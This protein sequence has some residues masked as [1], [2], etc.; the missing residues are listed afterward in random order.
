MSYCQNSLNL[1]FL[2]PMNFLY[3]KVGGMITLIIPPCLKSG[4]YI[5]PPSSPKSTPMHMTYI[6]WSWWNLYHNF[7]NA[8]D[9]E[10]TMLSTIIMPISWW[11]PEGKFIEHM[12]SEIE[13]LHSRG[14]YDIVY[15][16]EL[17][18]KMLFFGIVILIGHMSTCDTSN[19]WRALWQ[20]AVNLLPLKPAPQFRLSRPQKIA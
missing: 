6:R 4:G 1:K 2:R 5:S 20:R 14:P 8:T 12:D 7:H 16:A 19:S 3:K 18:W 15:F 17:W 11:S 13:N 9:E 10:S